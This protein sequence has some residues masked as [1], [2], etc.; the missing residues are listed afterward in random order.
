MH[1]ALEKSRGVL[2]LE[3]NLEHVMPK[4]PYANQLTKII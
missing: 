3:E 4:S 1:V 2:E